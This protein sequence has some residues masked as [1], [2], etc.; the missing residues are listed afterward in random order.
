MKQS[1]HVKIKLHLLLLLEF[2]L[3]EERAV[4]TREMKGLRTD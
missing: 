2:I 1:A 3:Q 4:N